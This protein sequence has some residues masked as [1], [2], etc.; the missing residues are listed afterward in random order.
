[1]TKK[2]LDIEYELISKLFI[3]SLIEEATNTDNSLVS[4]RV[5]CPENTLSDDDVSID[6]SIIEGEVEVDLINIP[7]VIDIADCGYLADMF[8]RAS[9]I[10][11]GLNNISEAINKSKKIK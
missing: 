11:H 6:I 7:S 5:K 1:M 2:E 4:I 10:G 3:R 8:Q 9:K